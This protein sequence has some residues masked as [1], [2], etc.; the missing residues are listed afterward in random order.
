MKKAA[1]LASAALHYCLDG[2]CSVRLLLF[3]YQ[4]TPVLK[5]QRCARGD[6][7]PV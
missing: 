2:F 4:A 1:H 5:R 6:S 7:A 3:K